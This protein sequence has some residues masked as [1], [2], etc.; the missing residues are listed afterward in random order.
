MLK[1]KIND[2]DSK[3]LNDVLG[4][5]RNILKITYFMII[6]VAIYVLTLIEKEWQVFSFIGTIFKI[7]SPLFIGMF[8]GWLFDP[9]VSKLQKHGIK[10]PWGAAITYMFIVGG[11]LL[12]IGSLIPS[13]SE[14][15]NDISK[16][17]PTVFDKIQLWLDNVFVWLSNIEGLDSNSMREE[18]FINIEK[19]STDLT[20][21]LPSITVNFLKSFFS[22]LGIILVGL[23][24]GF[25]ILISFGNVKIIDFLPIEMRKDTKKLFNN[26]D[27]SLRQFVKG[28]FF[29][30]TLVF[31]VTSILLWIVG[32]KAPVLFGLFCGL[33]NVIPYAGPY[34]GGIPA[35][36]FGFAQN[37][38]V[39]ILTLIVIVVVQ[40]FE[41]NFFQPLIMSKMIKLHPVT[42]MLGL[43]VFGYF[44]GIMGMF[45]STPIIAV[46]KAVFK[47]FD[48]KYD[49]LNF[50]N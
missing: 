39:G 13:L 38:T 50:Y 31:I 40:F 18:L 24:I 30:S 10:R 21:Q 9:L 16:N 1:E 32:L 35:V 41:G 8:I 3:K 37:P 12:V 43:L 27:D 14:Q 26:V 45:F 20:N 36:I 7:A 17:I 23:V 28:T 4:L 15:V 34:I 6:I 48:D 2:L 19:F 11:L 5:S 49:L 33:T 46:L 42:I 44:W 29:D 25:Y 22:G 47:F